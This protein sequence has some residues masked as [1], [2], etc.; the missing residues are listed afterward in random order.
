MGRHRTPQIRHCPSRVEN[1]QFTPGVPHHEPS[2]RDLLQEPSD[3]AL[4][5][6]LSQSFDDSSSIGVGLEPSQHPGARVAQR[7]VVEVH[8]ILGGYQTTH[9][10]GSGLFHQRDHG[11]F[12]RR[13]L[14][15]RRDEPR[16][17]PWTNTVPRIHSPSCSRPSSRTDLRCS[18]RHLC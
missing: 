15:V 4:L 3:G 8:G 1:R 10:I 12:G 13:A 14:R 16:S 18:C 6:V 11:S 2:R 9:P 17:R 7:T 5:L